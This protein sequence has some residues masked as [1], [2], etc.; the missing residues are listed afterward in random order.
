MICE[1]PSDTI[2]DFGFWIVQPFLRLSLEKREQDART[3]KKSMFT[4]PIDWL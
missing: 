3:T 4:N 1:N 2:L